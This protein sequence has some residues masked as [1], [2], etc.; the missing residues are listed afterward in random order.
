MTHSPIEFPM[1]E[2]GPAPQ[3]APTAEGLGLAVDDTL[4]RHAD[5]IVHHEPEPDDTTGLTGGDRLTLYPNPKNPSE[6]I[7]ISPVGANADTRRF[8]AMKG[9]HIHYQGG[10]APGTGIYRLYEQDDHRTVQ[11]WNPHPD[12]GHAGAV[13]VGL[14]EEARYDSLIGA[15][16]RASTE[17]PAS[18]FDRVVK[19]LGSLSRR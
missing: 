9:M 1:H 13:K 6:V 18:R 2:Q 12:L 4:A 17:R 19:A 5:S 7:T 11:V 8:P 15:L 14:S 16:S 3:F 10:R